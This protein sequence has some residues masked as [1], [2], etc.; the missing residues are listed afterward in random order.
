NETAWPGPA[1]LAKQTALTRR[2]VQKSIEQLIDQGYVGKR[3]LSAK[4]TND[5]VV[6]VVPRRTE[7]ATHCEQSSPA[8]RVRYEQSALVVV[9]GVRYSVRTECASGSAQSAPE[10]LNKLPDETTEE[11]NAA[12]R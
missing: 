1:R 5:L 8:N 4:G 2:G 12:L 10:L 7:C 3:G 9:N 6:N 11:T